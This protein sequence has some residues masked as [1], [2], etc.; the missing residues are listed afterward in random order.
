MTATI[1]FII[2]TFLEAIIEISPNEPLATHASGNL[3]GSHPPKD[4][5]FLSD[6]EAIDINKGIVHARESLVKICFVVWVSN[7]KVDVW[8]GSELRTTGMGGIASQ[9]P[10]SILAIFGQGYLNG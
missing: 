7:M 4:L 6:S 10:D 3:E 9:N 2:F 8:K 5:C 1:F